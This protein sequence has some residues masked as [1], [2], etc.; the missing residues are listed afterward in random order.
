[1]KEP[2]RKGVATH[3]GPESCVGVREGVGEALTGVRAGEPLSPEILIRDADAVMRSGR[4]H[5]RVRHR[6]CLA[7]PAGSETLSTHGNST[8][9]NWEISF[10]PAGHGRAGRTG[11]A[12]AVSS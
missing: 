11:K 10:L 5:G 8:R 7:G 3:P 9:E 6:K 4:Q 1:M 12:K 2:D